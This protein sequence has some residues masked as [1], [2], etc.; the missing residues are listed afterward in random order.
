MY[1][2]TFIFMYFGVNISISQILSNQIPALFLWRFLHCVLVNKG[3][4]G[5][6]DIYKF[7]IIHSVYYSYK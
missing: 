1:P 4:L 6:L 2:L 5:M 3:S 7:D